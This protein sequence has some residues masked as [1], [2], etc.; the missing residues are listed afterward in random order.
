MVD[1]RIDEGRRPAT[2]RLEQ[3]SYRVGT[4]M[5]VYRKRPTLFP[6]PPVILT[7]AIIAGLVLGSVSSAVVQGARIPVIVARQS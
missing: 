3:A 1:L 6:W 7:L 5:N 4:S 2:R